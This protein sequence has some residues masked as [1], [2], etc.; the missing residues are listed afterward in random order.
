MSFFKKLFPKKPIAVLT[1]NSDFIVLN[2]KNSELFAKNVFITIYDQDYRTKTLYSATK[3]IFNELNKNST[4]L[5]NHKK[6]QIKS[7]LIKNENV[8][9]NNFKGNI[10]IWLIFNSV[11]G[12][13]DYVIQIDSQEIKN[14]GNRI[15]KK[16]ILKLLNEL[17]C[18]LIIDNLKKLNINYNPATNACEMF[19]WS[20]HIKDIPVLKPVLKMPSSNNLKRQLPLNYENLRNNLQRPPPPNENNEKFR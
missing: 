13:F 14:N 17:D 10:K 4:N 2:K 16:L 12:I 19:K 18:K 20:F 11:T 8:S 9:Q 5:K 7:F 15:I 6:Y 3:E 1:N